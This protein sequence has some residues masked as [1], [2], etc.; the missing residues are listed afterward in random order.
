MKYFLKEA[1]LVFTAIHLEFSQNPMLSSIS[2][3]LSNALHQRM[4]EEGFPEKIVSKQ[5]VVNIVIGPDKQ[6][7]QQ[8]SLIHRTL[9]RAP[10]EQEIVQIADN[11]I[12]LKTTRY[13]NF[14]AFYEKFKSILKSCVDVVPGFDK[15]LLKRVMLRYIDVIAPSE[16]DSLGDF[17]SDEILPMSL[18]MLD[19]ISQRQGITVTRAIT[20]ESQV[21]Q[22]YFEEL[23]CN[24][25]KVHKL[26]PDNL[27]ETDP[28]CGLRIDGHE[29]WLSLT[30]ETYGI[31]DIDHQHSFLGSPIFD[32][33][34]L[35]ETL[36]NLY[37]DS[38]KVFWNTISVKAKDTWEIQE[39][40]TEAS[41]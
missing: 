12:I 26:L 21:L 16:N 41:L 34:F 23:P 30:S 25:G 17:V 13:N 38:S 4:I 19:G 18:S 1:P 32:L 37:E 33:L 10:G 24:D 28:Q 9:F 11:A 29:R 40:D 20:G 3:E 27:I 2:N 35:E 31:L 15:V 5:Q 8:A 36:K 39:K 22:V 14:E 6:P 7:L